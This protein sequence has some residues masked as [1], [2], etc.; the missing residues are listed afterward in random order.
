MEILDI[1]EE[2][3]NLIVQ[4]Y[5]RIC[6]LQEMLNHKPHTPIAGLVEN[7]AALN[8]MMNDALMQRSKSAFGLKLSAISNLLQTMIADIQQSQPDLHTSQENKEIES[9]LY[10]L[11][12]DFLLLQTKI[13]K[14]Q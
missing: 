3:G 6:I 14:S 10:L 13:N 1:N 7:G 8:G 9:I 4:M 12:S 2:N 5:Q 11:L